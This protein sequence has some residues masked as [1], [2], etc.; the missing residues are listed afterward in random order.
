MAFTD[1]GP[2]EVYGGSTTRE[3]DSVTTFIDNTTAA[4]FIPE[5]WST[6][7]TVSRESQLVFAKLVD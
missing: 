4:V 7:A 6:L 5:I 2:H 1:A 3:T